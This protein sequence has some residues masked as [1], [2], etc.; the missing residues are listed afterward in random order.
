[1]NT[2]IDHIKVDK[3]RT[4][5]ESSTRDSANSSTI[6]IDR[7]LPEKHKRILHGIK[8]QIKFVMRVCVCHLLIG[9]LIWVDY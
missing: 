2:F 6:L 1:M 3:L 5:I 7:I 4:F 8:M 9:F